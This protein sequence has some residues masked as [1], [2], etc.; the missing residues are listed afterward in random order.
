[1]P[2]PLAEFD[3]TVKRKDY[4]GDRQGC[5]RADRFDAVVNNSQVL[6]FRLGPAPQREA[7]PYI[8]PDITCGTRYSLM[9]SAKTTVFQFAIAVGA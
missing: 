2:N 9:P 5:A 4:Q 3:R 1:M 7:K 8:P 6:I